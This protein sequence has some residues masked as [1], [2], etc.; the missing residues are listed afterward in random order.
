MLHSIAQTDIAAVFS[1]WYTGT[2]EHRMHYDSAYTKITANSG[3]DQGCPSVSVWI[4]SSLLTLYSRSVMAQLCTHYDSGAKLFLPSW[5]IGTCGSN[6]SASYR[7][8]LVITSCYQISQPC[9]TVHQNTSMERLLQDPIPPEFLDKVTLTLSCL[10][11][12]YKIPGDTEPSLSFW[13]SR[14]PW[15]KQHNAFRKLLPRLQTSTLRD[16]IV[17]TVNDLLTMYV[18]QPVNMFSV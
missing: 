6:S 2:T 16:S 9:S 3:V 12:I 7:L 13:A 17:Q 4:L 11:D 14:L 5:T 10:E 1:K 8:L 15:R 18:V